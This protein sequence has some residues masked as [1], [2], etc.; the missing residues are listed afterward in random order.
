[1]P[2]RK[3]LNYLTYKVFQEKKTYSENI[4]MVFYDF[5]TVFRMSLWYNF[6]IA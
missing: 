2:T 5:L 6:F 1:M 3:E 4:S